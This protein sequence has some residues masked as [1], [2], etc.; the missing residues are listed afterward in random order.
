MKTGRWLDGRAPDFRSDLY[1]LGCTL[2]FL[3][4]GLP[5]FMGSVAHLT[6]QHRES[7]PPWDELPGLPPR[8]RRLLARLLA[9]DPALRPDSALEV[10]RELELCRA[11]IERHE[12][13]AARAELLTRRPR[14]LLRRQ[15]RSRIAAALCAL[16]V[17]AFG[18]LAVLRPLP[19]DAPVV[20][21]LT[22]PPALLDAPEPVVVFRLPPV[23]PR[24]LETQPAPIKVAPLPDEWFLASEREWPDLGTPDAPFW[25]A[26]FQRRLLLAREAEAATSSPIGPAELL[27]DA[28]APFQ[29]PLAT[30]SEGPSLWSAGS[31]D[32]FAV[33]NPRFGRGLRPFAARLALFDRSTDPFAPELRRHVA[34]RSEKASGRRK[35]SR[36]AKRSPRFD[37]VASLLKVHRTIGHTFARLF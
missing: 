27:A 10:R 36:Y 16:S 14:Q 5:P 12:A 1:S 18:A 17:L 26:D 31:P 33:A 23:A 13:L 3:L 6:A 25:S 21:A 30:T 37:P 15:P 19:E 22:P 29:S 35:G 11:S 9:K 7:E 24:A 32:P 4:D 34:H 8:L 28:G 20:A 2:W